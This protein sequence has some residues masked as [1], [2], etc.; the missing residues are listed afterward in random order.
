MTNPYD[1]WTPDLQ[2]Q[3]LK[4]V[5]QSIFVLAAGVAVVALSRL[6]NAPTMVIVVGYIGLA[7]AI[8]IAPIVYMTSGLTGGDES[9]GKIQRFTDEFCLQALAAGY[10]MVSWVLVV[11]SL[12]VFFIADDIVSHL[13]SIEV[14]LTQLGGSYVLLA[15][16]T[17][18]VTIMRLLKDDGE[19]ALD[20]ES[21]DSR[22]L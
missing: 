14:T 12:I 17:W 4:R 19:D 11:T 9:S 1:A 6:L 3:A 16:L 2:V 13:L 22:N 8:L 15:A 21:I 7:V 10:R 20:S 18:A 5:A